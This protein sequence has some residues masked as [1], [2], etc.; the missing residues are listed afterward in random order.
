[1]RRF[2]LIALACLAAPLLAA[3]R[4]TVPIQGVVLEAAGRP[5]ANARVLLFYSHDGT[6]YSSATLADTTTGAAGEF[7]LT[8]PDWSPPALAL[9]PQRPELLLIVW[10]EGHAV[11]VRPLHLAAISAA[12]P[13][14]PVRE[15]IRLAPDRPLTPTV[16]VTDGERPIAD[17]RIRLA[18][19]AAT[20]PRPDAGSQ[21][22]W[23]TGAPLPPTRTDGDGRAT[24][25]HLPDAPLRLLIEAP[26]FA[27]AALE[28]PQGAAMLTARLVPSQLLTGTVRRKND[29]SPQAGMVVLMREPG[30][31]LCHWALTDANGRY[32]LPAATGTKP[33]RMLL[34][35]DPGAEPRLAPGW[36]SF[37]DKEHATR[38]VDIE[39][40]PGH[41]ITGRL[42][43]EMDSSPAPYLTVQLREGPGS[44]EIFRRTDATG[45]WRAVVTGGWI[46]VRPLP[47]APAGT[48]LMSTPPKPKW[49]WVLEPKT[50]PDITLDLRPAASA[51][52]VI[53]NPQGQPAAGATLHTRIGASPPR[54]LAADAAGQAL[55]TDVPCGVAFPLYAIAA[56]AQAAACRWLQLDA[57]SDVPEIALPLEPAR[58]AAVTTLDA[59]GWP[60][61]ATVEI[62]LEDL[63]PGAPATPPRPQGGGLGILLGRR[64]G[65][66]DVLFSGLL[67]GARYRLVAAVNEP[68]ARIEGAPHAEKQFTLAGDQARATVEIRLNARQMHRPWTMEPNLPL[69]Q[70]IE[71]LGKPLWTKQ[72]AADSSLT[73]IVLDGGLALADA[74]RR[75]VQRFYDF[76]GYKRFTV[77]AI[78]FAKDRTWVGTDVGLFAWNRDDRFWTRMAVNATLLEVPVVHLEVEEN[79]VLLVTVELQKGER[80]RYEFNPQTLKWRPRN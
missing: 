52:I 37:P 55:L 24:L 29:G 80:A 10:A 48:V 32:A 15:S 38:T 23:L 2:F 43:R 14:R 62:Y 70:Q 45:T 72:D 27:P 65:P 20:E 17:A 13:Q 57:T 25:R 7:A 5:L 4:P 36:S 76:F 73:W 30:S 41:L 8:L 78:A 12:A 61:P 67:P 42:L 51:R 59:N 46:S 69:E 63:P 34:A 66:G 3:E 74:R 16:I 28:V 79:G 47:L 22:F 40:P 50:I 53:S 1:M 21:M 31:D 56:H 75:V 68:Q 19:V 18:A 58:T 33:G 6:G 26:G 35:L 39:M 44:L 71:K 9:A 49:V 11:T 77:N 60:L 64:A 54:S